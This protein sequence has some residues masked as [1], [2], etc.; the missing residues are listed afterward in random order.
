VRNIATSVDLACAP[1]RG[2]ALLADVRRVPEWVP[3]VAD[4]RVLEADAAGRPLRVRFVSMP[5]AGSLDYV[6]RYSYD[7]GARTLRWQ[8]DDGEQRSVEGEARI[9]E[10]PGGCRLDYVLTTWVARTLPA[11]AQSSLAD[12]TPERTAR[13]FQRWAERQ[14]D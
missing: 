13:A 12:D 1:E 5:N 3:G 4:A 7:D 11:W 6:L 10:R 14:T 2:W 8:T 9:S